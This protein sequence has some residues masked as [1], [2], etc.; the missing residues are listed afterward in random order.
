MK[1]RSKRS[2]KMEKRCFVHRHADNNIANAKPT[3]PV[4]VITFFFKFKLYCMMS[5]LQVMRTVLIVSLN[6]TK[7]QVYCVNYMERHMGGTV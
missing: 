2:Q 5:S 3:K 6:A 1:M 7:E 4:Y